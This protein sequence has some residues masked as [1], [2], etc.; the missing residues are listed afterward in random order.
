MQAEVDKYITS[1]FLFG[2]QDEG[3][4]FCHLTQAQDYQLVRN[5]LERNV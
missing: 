4:E 2:Q 1:R 5:A 3:R